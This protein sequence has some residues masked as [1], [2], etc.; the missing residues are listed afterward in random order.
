[1]ASLP[2]PPMASAAWNA[3]S[4]HL[5]DPPKHATIAFADHV[6]ALHVSGA[7]RLRREIG[8]RSVGGWFGPGAVN[9]L[10]AGVH[11]T[12][13][14]TGGA[15]A[16]VLAI[17]P[18]YLSRVI[19]EAWELEPSGVEIVGQFLVRDPVIETVLTRLGL[20]VRNGSPSGQLYAVSACDFLANHIIHAYSSLSAR[21]PRFAGGLAG[22]RLQTVLEYVEATLARPISLRRLAELAGVSARHFERAFRQA[23]GVAPHAYVLQRRIAAARHLLLTQPALSIREIAAQAGF[24]SASHLAFAFRRQ[25]G[26]PP[27]A[28][29]RLQSR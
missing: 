9:L 4:I 18:A 19:E 1:M 25:T 17:P 12:W 5:L 28:F 11:A 10:A 29:R 21:P 23:V 27:S 16:I 24:S 14:G 15:H 7:G 8:G 20:E 26:Y 13:D 3:F 2:D 6:L 22:Q